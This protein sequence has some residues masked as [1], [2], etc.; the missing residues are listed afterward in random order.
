MLVPKNNPPGYKEHVICFVLCAFGEGAKLIDWIENM[1]IYVSDIV[2]K[3]KTQS[4]VIWE[5]QVQHI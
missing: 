4:L 3:Y 2:E 5:T 1:K